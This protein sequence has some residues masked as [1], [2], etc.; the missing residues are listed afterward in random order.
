MSNLFGGKYNIVNGLNN[1]FKVCYNEDRSFANTDWQVTNP[2]L[3]S[4]PIFM[5]Q[6]SVVILFTRTFII[7]LTPIRQP[8]F[9]SEILAGIVLGPS[10]L[11]IIGWVSSNINPF[12]GALLLETMGNLGVTFYMFLVGL[13]MDLT[14]IRKMGKTACSVAI[15]GIVL[16][17]CGGAGLY[18]L[19]LQKDGRRPSEGGL[20]WAIALTVTSFPDLARMLSSLK[21]MYTDLGKT[22]LTSAVLTDLSSWILL[23]AVVSVVNGRG[24]LYTV[25]P[26]MLFLVISWFLMRPFIL[27]AVK[28][29]ALRNESS[30][31]SR[32]NEKQVC[33][34]LSGVLLCGFFTEMCGVHSMFGA[35]MFGLMI[36]SGELG[37]M[38]MDKIE[39]YV[40]GILLPPVFL[41]TGLRTNFAYM[42]VEHTS[43]LVIIVILVASSVKIVSTLLV[44]LYLKCPIR[45]SLAL[46]VL[47]NTKGVLA[48]IVLNEGRNVKGFDQQTFSWLVLSILIMTGLVG[49]IVNFTHKSTRYTKKYYR[50]NLE[51][52]KVEAELR[53]LACVHSSK[54][55]SGLINLLHISNATRK[56]PITVF[57]VHLVELTGRASAMLI[58]HDKTRTTNVIGNEINPISRGKAEA[59]QIVS[60]FESFHNDNHAVY[61]Q[62]LTAVSSYA[63]MHEDVS[64]FALDK[65]VTV[66]LLPFHKQANAHGGWTDENLQHKQVTD[67]LLANAPCSIGIL[68]DRGL[69]PPYLP[70]GSPHDRKR[71]CRIA[72]LF[73]QGPDYREALAY[74]WRMAG[75]S[76]VMLT[77]V[78]FIPGKEVVEFAETDAGNGGGDDDDDEIF[79]ATFEKEKEMLLD[80]DYI[81]EFRFRTMHNQSISYIEKQVNSGDQIVS[82]IR[83]TYNDFDLY[84]VGRGHGM[85][86]PLTVG[87]SDWSNCPELGLIGETLGAADFLPS[88][89]VLVMQ[90]STP[91][92]SAPKKIVSSARKKEVFKNSGQPSAVP[93]VNHRKADDYY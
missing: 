37:T 20:F 45:D 2:L 3:K 52:S 13:E 66:I 43:H 55:V 31:E 79:A 33:Y 25:I 69:T 83:S 19:V 41:I 29:I 34:I 14:P 93:F 11:G 56:F 78:R 73:L 39:E 23:V 35:F 87:L 68:V 7:V 91:P 36:P 47:M 17:A 81:N 75:T 62:P 63:S 65:G 60:A 21:L 92:P 42:A 82:I 32:Y 54:N 48:I 12:E 80:D 22:A 89:S 24:K 77:V 5:L 67:N 28:R 16:P 18:Y 88:G 59:E 27:W 4:L 70:L 40:V 46:G 84:I 49:P 1:E 44:C 30:M 86:S 64:N 58:F 10:A 74:A 53:V 38:I 85:Q 15:A 51:R 9:V 61:V 90:Q 8:R 72:M 76:G 71:K 57:A 26:T 6:L 50:R